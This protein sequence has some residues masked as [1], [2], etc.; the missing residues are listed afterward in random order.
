M[1]MV[2]KVMPVL[3]ACSGCS[4][5]GQ[6]ASHVA[7]ALDRQGLAEMSS[8]AGIGADDP[9]AV[10]KARSRFPIIAIDGC[11]M[12]CARRCLARHGVEPARHYVLSSYGVAKR[13]RA[14]FTAEEAHFVLQAIAEDLQGESQ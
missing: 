8:I 6:L 7:H 14:D 11:P 12:A 1:R 5:A 2:V 10:G 9:Q 4:S 13:A 3:Y